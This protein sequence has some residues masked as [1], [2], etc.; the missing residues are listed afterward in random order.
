MIS[1]PAIKLLSWV[2]AAAEGMGG[3]YNTIK[4]PQWYDVQVRSFILFT[5]MDK[6]QNHIYN[7]EAQGCLF[8]RTMISQKW[9]MTN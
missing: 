1:Q 9:S 6:W 7:D 2:S 3:F 5:K 8:A 4:N